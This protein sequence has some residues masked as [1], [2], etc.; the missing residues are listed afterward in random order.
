MAL[1]QDDFWCN[2]L[3]S[4]ANR[5]RSAF[6]K[7]LCE[8]EVCKF[9]VAIV[10]NQQVFGLEI[11]EDDVLAVEILE[12]ASHCCPIKLGLFGGEG[13]YRAEVSE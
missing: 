4:S 5:E 10:S 1:I 12:T 2:V 11:T 9:E 13:L 3:R 8:T 6:I 7:Y